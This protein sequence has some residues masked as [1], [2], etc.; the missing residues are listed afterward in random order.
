MGEVTFYLNGHPV[1]ASQGD[2]VLNAALKN[3][4]YIPHLCYH[5]DLEPFGS[6]RVCLV[7]IEG[8]GLAVSCRMPVEEGLKVNTDTPQVEEVRRVAV[9]LILAS[10][11]SECLTCG[12][13]GECKLQEV[14]N[15][16]GID[17]ARLARLK[18][19]VK[20]FP[21]DASNPFFLR[22]LNKCIL[23]GICVRSCEEIL[24]VG[25]IDFAYRGFATKIAT[26]KDKPIRESSCVSCGECVARCPVGAL[27]P[28]DYRKPAAEIRTVCPYCG[29]GCG[30]YLGVR[31][32]EVVMAKGDRSSPV[33]RGRLCVKGRFGYQFVHSPDRLTKPLIKQNGEFRE[34]TWEEALDRVAEKLAAYKGDQFAL[35]ASA[36]CTNEDAYVLQKFARAVMGTNNVDHCARLCHAPSLVGLLKVLG[37]GAMTNP[38]QD[39]R[40]AA[41]LLAVGTNTTEAHP[42]VGLEIGH[43]VRKGA[44]LIVVNPQ[45]VD[46]CRLAHLHLQLRPGSDVALIMGMCRVI[47][48]ENRHDAAFI[49]ARTE[50]FEEFAASLDDFPLERVEELT[51]VPKEKIVEA[52]RILATHKPAAILW[53]MGITQHSHGT[54]NVLALANLAL[55]TGNLGK[56]SCGLYPL[57]GQNNVQGACDMGCLYAFYPGYQPVADPQVR[58][59]FEAF[60]G[61]KL[62]PNPGRPLTEIWSA[63]LRGEIRAL[64]L[65]GADPMLTVADSNRVREALQKAEF[66]VAQ[67]LFM[68][69]TARMAHVL[70][71]AASFAEKDGTFT[72][73]ERRVQRVRRA[74]RPVGE[75]RPDWWI[76]SQL[77]KRMGASG[78]EFGSPE[79]IMAEIARVT[80]SYA[81]ITY[82]R[83]EKGGIQWPCPSPD[84]PGTPILFTER[85]NTASG[86][87]RFTPLAYRGPAEIPDE[88]YPFVLTTDRSLYHFHTTMSRKVGGLNDLR[89]EEILEINPEDARRLG[90]QDGEVVEVASRRGRV[91]AR[92]KLTKHT[93]R[94]LV[95][96]TFHFAETPTNVL[97]DTALDPLAKIP[98]TKVC[99]VRI[100]K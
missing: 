41:C 28:K 22:D 63:V 5:P 73:T 39:L 81:G 40:D 18:K 60:W 54:D 48:E 36:K 77:A 13:N 51:G 98:A 59:K 78:F 80:P 91:K 95:S 10:H 37:S 15:Y 55:L 84:H 7:E 33:N 62:N 6:C 44:K 9:E 45:R 93:P 92:A 56:P 19:L 61:A 90:I 68:T 67:D 82:G 31:G 27:L 87:A 79:E 26:L 66:V 71:P 12:K 29:C 25:A 42:I 14:A 17:P 24:G 86:R 100:S 96:M 32:N 4:Y 47:L 74:I 58:E 2:T 99:A 3:G 72:N 53:S 16:V 88:E 34:A 23:C 38:I 8:Q 43:A 49:A 70:L 20:D 30:L 76:V 57:R 75:A 50:G 69:E 35:I 1:R 21:V 89:G 64:Y 85:F 11:P 52:A 46:L 94:G 83:L 97:T 65:V